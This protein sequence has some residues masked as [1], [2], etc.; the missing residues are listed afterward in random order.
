VL[1][2]QEKILVEAEGRRWGLDRH[3]RLLD[4]WSARKRWLKKV[5]VTRPA[6]GRATHCSG[7]SAVML[8]VK[9]FGRCSAR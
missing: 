2:A 1:A 7:G 9:R 4:L 6:Y 5:S 3:E 8:A